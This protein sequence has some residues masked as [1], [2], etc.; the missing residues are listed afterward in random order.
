[1]TPWM[2]LPPNGHPAFWLAVLA[3]KI[4]AWGLLFLA[5]ITGG[6]W[7]ISRGP[8]AGFGLAA[9]FLPEVLAN[10]AFAHFLRKGSRIA[11]ALFGLW[12][13]WGFAKVI[14]GDDDPI[15]ALIVY[16]MGV[17]NVV[18]LI[19]VAKAFFARTSA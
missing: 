10:F 1:M 8:E 4:M 9:R 19:G 3:A 12:C 2:T 17:L 13:L 16:V 15:V 6:S 5:L 7:A 11:A 18:G 14:P